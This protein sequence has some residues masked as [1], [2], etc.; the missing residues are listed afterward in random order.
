[1]PLFTNMHDWERW[2][3][4]EVKASLK[5]SHEIL[6][7]TAEEFEKRVVERTPVGNP[8]AWQKPPSKPYIPGNLKR[9][10]KL[11]KHFGL[12]G[13]T[14]AV[15]SNDAEY[16]ARVEYGWSKQAPHGMMRLTLLEI[17][18]IIRDVAARKG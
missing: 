10:W 16:A 6:E 18:D 14:K 15:V 17:H 5:L 1:M 12:N 9:S 7:D 13:I 2:H 11:D 4:K 3:A 8:S